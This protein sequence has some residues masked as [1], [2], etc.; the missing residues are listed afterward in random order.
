VKQKKIKASILIIFGLLLPLTTVQAKYVSDCSKIN[1]DGP[2]V[3][4][5]WQ[6][7]EG[8]SKLWGT[9]KALQW[10]TNVPSNQKNLTGGE[11]DWCERTDKSNYTEGA[12]KGTIA[13]LTYVKNKIPY[14]VFCMNAGRNAPSG[15]GLKFVEAIWDAGPACAFDRF[16]SES[17]STIK[18]HNRIRYI[19][20][21]ANANKDVNDLK[22]CSSTYPYGE[23][24]CLGGTKKDKPLNA[25]KIS[26]SKL[27]LDATN[28][29][30]QYYV[31]KAT[32]IKM[33]GND[34]GTPKM[35]TPKLS[36]SIAG[37]IVVTNVS[38][39]TETT[40]TDASTLYIKIPKSEITTTTQITLKLDTE[41]YKLSCKY[42]RNGIARYEDTNQASAFQTIAFRLGEP[43]TV[44]DTKTATASKQLTIVPDLPNHKIISI[45]K[46]DANDYDNQLAGAKFGLF[47]DNTCST[48]ATDA[49]NQS[50]VTTNG[51]GSAIFVV[52]EGTTYYIK[53]LSAPNNYELNSRC[54]LAD[55]NNEMVVENIKQK[56]EEK[57]EIVITKTETGSNKG[58]SGVIFELYK[59]DKVTKATDI[60]GKEIGLI[61]T[62]A[63]GNATI[64]NLA[65]GTYYLKEIEAPNIYIKESQLLEVTVNKSQTEIEIDNM[66]ITVLFSK[67]D[68]VTENII[69]GGK[70]RIEKES[71]ELVTEFSIKEDY[72]EL[73]ME[74]GNY[75]FI[76]VEAPK[77]YTNA[78]INFN[79]NVANNGDVTI[80]SE[81]SQYYY[82]YE[83]I[84][85]NI[86]NDKI[87]KVVE[88]PKTGNNTNKTIIIVSLI[89]IGVGITSIVIIKKKKITK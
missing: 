9:T 56:E 76:E 72:Y 17:N 38:A 11:V 14:R 44:T 54:I 32:G 82:V 49:L 39:T 66:P 69:N 33:T 47:S 16:A 41:P 43:V 6:K 20:R 80:T 15:V 52:E 10:G 37:A 57:G 89:L 8:L 19:Q 28:S 64:S 68:S 18:R 45:L 79:F 40:S 74:P 65:Y 63:K 24:T 60:D 53:E 1:I 23:T 88:V 75:K 27:E 61:K 81:E 30:D 50:E 3:K 51:Y 86:L 84:T 42:T 25:G 4:A 67:R 34:N 62:D 13:E 12:N 21:N 7:E 70:Y 48:P 85:I 55:T 5:Y 26:I 36:P 77:D 22:K 35:Y 58:I 78:N 29:N 83:G 71:G 2:D 31:Y 46:V 87:E 73:I 59:S